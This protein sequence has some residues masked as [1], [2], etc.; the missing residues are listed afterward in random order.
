MINWDILHT[1]Q[2]N[3]L[4][5]VDLKTNPIYFCLKGQ[6]AYRKVVEE[7][8]PEIVAADGTIDRRA[9]G[10][11]VFSDKSRLSTLNSIVWPQISRLA[12]EKADEL[13]RSGRQIVVLDAAVL[14]EAGWQ[15]ACHE[16]W[17]CLVPRQE[18]IK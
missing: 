8:G 5:I 12:L 14:L 18:A 15:S 10:G 2:V 16:V 11:I 13:W 7:F 3:F 4:Y 17:V 6:E 1:L 9:L